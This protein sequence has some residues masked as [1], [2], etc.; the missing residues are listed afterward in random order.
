M[1]NKIIGLI[2]G[3]LLALNLNAA[4]N[5]SSAGA[6]V[7]IN[8]SLDWD[9]NSNVERHPSGSGKIAPASKEETYALVVT[10]VVMFLVS[11]VV[12]NKFLPD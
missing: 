5:A 6:Y 4:Y 9:S 2:V 1:K 10:A 7:A 3:I 8:S 11:Y 12:I